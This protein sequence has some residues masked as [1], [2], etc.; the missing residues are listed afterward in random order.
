MNEWSDELSDIK[1]E[2]V[3][4]RALVIKTNHLTSALAA[5][6]RAIAKRQQSFERTALYNSAFAFAL[7]A[8]VVLGSV[9]V[10]WEARVESI[11]RSTQQATE[12]ADR[13]RKDLEA[14]KASQTDR[15]RA[16]GAAAAF[17]DLVR[18]GRR[19]E[20]IEGFAKL[21]DQP[22]SRAELAFFGDAVERAK[23][24]LSV[25]SY[26]AGLDGAR[27]GRWVESARSLEESLALTE[28]ASHSP[29]AKLELAR[30]YRKLG[31]QRDAIALLSPLSEASPNPEVLDD[32]TFLLA[33]CLIDLQAYN[34]ARATLRAFVRRFPNSSYINDAK[35]ALSDL[36]LKR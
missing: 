34:D 1:R 10:A 18:A 14:T 7:F 13:A 31:R 24:E 6:L 33:E 17:Y 8:A 4:S 19:R 20:L 9:Y 3:E 35:L 23:S 36:N 25:E 16:E 28:Q 15:N 5:D 21:R 30:A 11:T 22:L 2:I 32:A 27:S 12:A 26:Q 29:S